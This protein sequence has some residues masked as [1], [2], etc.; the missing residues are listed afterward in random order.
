MQY[1]YTGMT[2]LR[3]LRDVTKSASLSVQFSQNTMQRGNGGG[4]Q[5][6]CSKDAVKVHIAHFLYADCKKSTPQI[7]LNSKY[8][9]DLVCTRWNQ[10]EPFEYILFAKLKLLYTQLLSL[11]NSDPRLFSQILRSAS[12]WSAGIKY[13][14]ESIHNAYVHVIENSQHFIY[15]EVITSEA[16]RTIE[17]CR[18]A[19]FR[20]LHHRNGK[21]LPFFWLKGGC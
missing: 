20:L 19:Q 16:K 6:N 10:T 2:K 8:Y 1:V 5:Q 18:S 4:S 17:E 9:I 21:L 14:E 7:T 12:D 11:L 3:I 13:H 15:I